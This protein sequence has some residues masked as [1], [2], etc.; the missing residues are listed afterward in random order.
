MG[1]RG[2]T[3]A[4]TGGGGGG[5]F[6]YVYDRTGEPRLIAAGG[7]GAFQI[8]DAGGPGTFREVTIVH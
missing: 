8:G 1:Q 5:S 6:V 4:G 3:Y 7:G 2:K